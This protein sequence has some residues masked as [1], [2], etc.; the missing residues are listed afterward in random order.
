MLAVEVQTVSKKGG[1]SKGKSTLTRTFEAL[2]ADGWLCDKVEQPYNRFTKRTN[3][4]LGFID[5]IAIRRDEVRAIQ[6]TSI[7][8]M[9]ARIAKIANNPNAPIWL[10]SPHR[11]IFVVGWAK[12]G[13]R[14]KRKVWTC[15]QKQMHRINRYDTNENFAGYKIVASDTNQSTQL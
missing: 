1:M 3:D 14:G 15:K 2:R 11:T 12:R 4:F 8:N 7:G 6:A 13:P 10:D 9:N 5:G